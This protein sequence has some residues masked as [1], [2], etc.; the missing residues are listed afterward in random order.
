[1]CSAVVRILYSAGKGK[2]KR[3]S[4]DGLNRGI[5]QRRRFFASPLVSKLPDG[6]RSNANPARCASCGENPLFPCQN[7]K[8]HRF[9]GASFCAK[10]TKKIFFVSCIKVSN[11]SNVNEIVRC[12]MK[13]S[14]SSDEIFSLRLQM[15][16]NP[17]IFCHKADFIAKRFHPPQVD[18][19]RRRRI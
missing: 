13:S 14:L 8:K 17:P 5:R 18:L 15:K 10:A 9:C 1:M 6:F 19:F 3:P 7:E 12:T 11:P 4:S 16:S 2:K